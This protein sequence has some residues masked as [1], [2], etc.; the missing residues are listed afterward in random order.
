MSIFVVFPVTNWVLY[1]VGLCSHKDIE[2]ILLQ[3]LFFFDKDTACWM[4]QQVEHQ[5]FS[6]NFFSFINF[7]VANWQPIIPVFRGMSSAHAIFITA[8]SIYLIVTTDLFSDRIKGPITFRSSIISTSA[9]GVLDNSS[10]L[11][12]SATKMFSFHPGLMFYCSTH[13]CVPA[14]W[15]TGFCRLLHHWSCYDLLVV[16]LPWWN[17][18]CRCHKNS[19]MSWHNC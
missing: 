10:T 17:G 14:V 15:L 13:M 11:L 5:S 4:E 12:W 16:S 19:Y 9:L 3:G 2:L 18:I 8:I 6:F 7:I 1:P